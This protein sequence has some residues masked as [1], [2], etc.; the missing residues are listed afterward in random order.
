MKQTG[1]LVGL[2]AMAFSLACSGGSG[3]EERDGRRASGTASG[4]LSI[5]VIPKGTSRV[6]AE[7]P[8]GRLIEAARGRVGA[9]DLAAAPC[10]RTT[11]TARYRKWAS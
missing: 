1:R 11:A 10:A 9:S 5:A 8:R 6:L 4:T 2:A 3:G 7:H